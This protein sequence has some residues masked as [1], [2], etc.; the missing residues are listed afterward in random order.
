MGKGIH[1]GCRKKYQK[2]SNG[3]NIFSNQYTINL[4]EVLSYIETAEKELDTRPD[5]YIL[6]IMPHFSGDINY[7]GKLYSLN[8]VPNIEFEIYYGQIKLK[9][10]EVDDTTYNTSNK[11]EFINTI[12][13]YTTHISYQKYM[14]MGLDIPLNFA[15]KLIPS[16]TFILLIVAGIISFPA[17][18][19]IQH[20]PLTESEKIDKK[21]KNRIVQLKGEIN[22]SG[23]SFFTV[24]SFRDLVN[25]ADEKELNILCIKED[26]LSKYYLT[27][28]DYI[29]CYNCHH[30]YRALDESNNEEVQVS[31]LHSYL[32]SD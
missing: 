4:K 22:L 8:P 23:K 26:I 29:Y 25:I 16:L 32:E 28:G 24:D 14:L 18:K 31:N 3:H 6:K 1:L 5:R 27:D 21:Y 19:K 17:L 12:P 15:K 11:K 9:E 20:N 30:S 7:D 13:V 10:D 2:N